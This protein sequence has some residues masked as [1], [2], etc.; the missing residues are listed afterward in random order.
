MPPMIKIIALSGSLIGFLLL[1]EQLSEA[2][3]HHKTCKLYTAIWN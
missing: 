2:I 1:S 3:R